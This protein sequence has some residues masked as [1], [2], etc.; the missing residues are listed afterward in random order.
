MLVVRARIRSPLA[1]TPSEHPGPLLVARDAGWFEVDG[2]HRIHLGRR[3]SLRRVLERLVMLRLEAPGCALSVDGMFAAGWPNER[4]EPHGVATRVFI[5]VQRLRG[6]GLAQA[7]V[8]RDDGYLLD[9]NVELSRE[10]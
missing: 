5:A 6:L 7:V 3:G 1:T 8:S 10:P 4:N 9:P 2:E